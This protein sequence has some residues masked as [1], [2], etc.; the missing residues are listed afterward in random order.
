MAKRLLAFFLIFGAAAIFT[1]ATPASATAP[2]ITRVSPNKGPIVGGQTV[3]ITGTGFTGVTGASSVTFGSVNATSYAVM[4]DTQIVAVV[5]NASAAGSQTIVVTN[6]TGASSSTTSYSY[7]APTIKSITPAYAKEDASS[8]ITITGTG[9]SGTQ[10]ADVTFADGTNTNA[11]LSVWVV[12]D[13]Q[14]VVTTPID[15]D[16]GTTGDTSDDTVVANGVA[17]VII[18]RNGVATTP[19]TNSAFL[20]T[21]GLATITGLTDGTNAVT[22][23]DGVAAGS[24]LTITGTQLW[25]VTQVAFGSAKVTNTS[26]IS[27]DPA[28]TSMTVK[29][30]TRS[31]GPVDVVVTNAAGSSVTNL[32]TTFNYL[33]SSAP[34]VNAAFPTALDKAA[35]S[36]VLITGRGFTGVGAS[37][38]TVTCDSS[39]VTP[40]SVTAVSD[41]SLILVMP[42]QTAASTCDVK[43]DNPADNTK[44]V[45]KTG[46]FRYI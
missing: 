31:A 30:P 3:V 24:D 41:T 27:V 42:T 17:N 10:A 21:P 18:T 4:S 1:V 7:Q 36:S 38:V 46:L 13:S 33:S 2:T 43:V 34:T 29:V 19:D 5:P 39:G 15:D 25:G 32:K 35:A 9:L 8:I 11:A 20:F 23:T 37:Q 28:G 6:S 22:G 44:T 12:S 40:T 26:D 14:I 16:N 45:T